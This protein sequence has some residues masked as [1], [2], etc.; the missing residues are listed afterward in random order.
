MTIERLDSGP[1]MSKAVAH[2]DTI[3]LA[4]LVAD[5]LTRD[6]AGQT[7]EVLAKI[8]DYLARLGSDKSKLLRVEIWLS[9]MGTFG[10]MNEAYD[11]WVDRDNPPVRACVE[12]RLAG[13][14]YLVE[15]MATAAR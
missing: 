13:P 12:A 15:I 11:A 5:D 9:H 4:G 10:Q 8:D 6:T 7:T 14:N 3:Y 2:G 1:R